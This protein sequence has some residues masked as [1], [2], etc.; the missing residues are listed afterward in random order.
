M[1]QAI[2]DFAEARRKKRV[3][4]GAGTYDSESKG[5]PLNDVS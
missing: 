5:E 1:I 4:G 2:R 3:A